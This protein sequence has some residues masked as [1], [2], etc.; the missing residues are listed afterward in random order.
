M[1]RNLKGINGVIVHV[2]ETYDTTITAPGGTKFYVN[3]TIDDM[4]YVVR[5]GEVVTSSDPR[6]KPGDIA[7]FH[8]NMVK[9]RSVEYVDGKVGSSNELFDDMFIIPVEFVYLVKR[10]EDH[11]AIDPWCYVSTVPN[12]K[13]KEGSIEIANADKYKKQHGIMVYS[14]DSLREQGVNDGTPVV[15]NLDSEYEIKKNDKEQ[16]RKKKKTKK[17]K[18][19]FTV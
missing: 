9:R 8:H 3:N 11:L 1:K 12:D 2:P 6:I 19:N 5:H 4:T 18:K 15:L 14:N 10:G 16:Y 13:F 17:K 7:Y